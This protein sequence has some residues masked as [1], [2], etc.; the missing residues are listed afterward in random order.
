MVG[1]LSYPG[2][3][4][5]FTQKT[6]VIFQD[7]YLFKYTSCGDISSSPVLAQITI[8]TLRYQPCPF[9][10][11]TLK[12]CLRGF[13]PPTCFVRRFKL[14][15]CWI[16]IKHLYIGSKLKSS[17]PQRCVIEVIL[18]AV[19]LNVGGG[20]IHT[21]KHHLLAIKNPPSGGWMMLFQT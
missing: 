6:L 17:N 3:Y 14:L 5:S 15:T 13:L 7:S 16:L 21:L 18:V 4:R 20:G 10:T 12:H 9:V 2:E 1:Q 19:A 11:A 8:F